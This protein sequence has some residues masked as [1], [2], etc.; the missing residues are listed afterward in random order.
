MDTSAI[1]STP[2]SP[3]R[4]DLATDHVSGISITP[5]VTAQAAFPPDG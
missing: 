3:W 1:A 5:T 2:T 4:S